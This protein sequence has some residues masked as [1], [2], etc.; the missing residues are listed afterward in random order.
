MDV[1]RWVAAAAAIMLGIGVTI[2][3][4]APASAV[5]YPVG[6]CDQYQDEYW[7]EF[8]D[9]WYLAGADYGYVIPLYSRGCTVRAPQS[10]FGNGLVYSPWGPALADELCHEAFPDTTEVLNYGYNVYYCANFAV[11]TG[12]GSSPIPAWVQAYG[13]DGMDATC[14]DGWNPSWQEW[15]QEVTGGWVCTRS[16]PSLG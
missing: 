10:F 3:G 4:A 7:V 16:I 11:V 8:Y 15:A 6:E 2:V 5:D 1:H 12:G 9:S 14:E 13:R